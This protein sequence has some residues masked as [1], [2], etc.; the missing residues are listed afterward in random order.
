MLDVPLIRALLRALPDRAALLLVGEV[1]RL[2]NAG[3]VQMWADIIGSGAVQVI[4][5]TE[6]FRQAAQS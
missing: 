6:V 1:D 5:L 3:P 4:R 2:P